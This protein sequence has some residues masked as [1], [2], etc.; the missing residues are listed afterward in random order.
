[1]ADE[2]I[3]ETSTTFEGDAGAAEENASEA[4]AEATS[5]APEPREDPTMRDLA[6]QPAGEVHRQ[7]PPAD[8][9]KGQYETLKAEFD[10]LKAKYSETADRADSAER[11]KEELAAATGR[12]AEVE[13]RLLRQKVGS[14]FGIP[15]ALVDRLSGDDY[16]AMALDAK[17]LSAFIGAPSGGLGKGGLDPNET[18][19]DAKKFVARERSKLYSA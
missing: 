9:F 19:F 2:I 13:R 8:D 11:F 15:S 4:A 12:V 16:E 18:A 6:H 17:Q 1:M 14:E 10:V 5:E 3:D 7:A